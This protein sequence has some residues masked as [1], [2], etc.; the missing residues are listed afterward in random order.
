MGAY[1]IRYGD[2]W[3]GPEGTVVDTRHTFDTVSEARTAA[4]LHAAR[5]GTTV[6]WARPSDPL[7]VTSVAA[8]GRRRPSRRARGGA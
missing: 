8:R 1:E 7:G 6:T 3:I 4:H 5:I 2:G